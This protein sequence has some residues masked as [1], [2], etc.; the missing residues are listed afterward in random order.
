MFLNA[1]HI[2]EDTKPPCSILGAKDSTVSLQDSNTHSL[3]LSLVTSSRTLQAASLKYCFS[4]ELTITQSPRALSEPSR[5]QGTK[6]LSTSR[7]SQD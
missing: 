1:F 2:S 7:L 5:G 3:M 4:F 6:L